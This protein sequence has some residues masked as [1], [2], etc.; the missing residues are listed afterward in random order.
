MIQGPPEGAGAQILAFIFHTPFPGI[1]I[2]QFPK[3]IVPPEQVLGFCPFVDHKAG[4]RHGKQLGHG[5]GQLGFAASGL[6]PDQQGAAH[7]Q[8]RQD[9]HGLFP[10]KMMDG[11]FGPAF[12]GVQVDRLFCGEGIKCYFMGH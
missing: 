3:G 2:G 10:V 12:A 4:Q 11:G 6:S 1:G 7:S 9:G 5:P 8:G